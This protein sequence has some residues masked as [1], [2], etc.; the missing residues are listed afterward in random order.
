M[1]LKYDALEEM[2][3]NATAGPWV[4]DDN[5]GF[6]GWSIWERMTPTGNGTPGKKIAMIYDDGDGPEE[7]AQFIAA[8]RNEVPRLI[9]DVRAL[10]EALKE[11]IEDAEQREFEDWLSRTKPSGDA[12]RVQ[13]EWERSAEF[14]DVC[15]GWKSARA[16]LSR[17]QEPK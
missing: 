3:K 11:R 16:A 7:D 15:E 2:A 14:F 8:A 5:E 12:E 13:A 1:K 9:A 10:A 17:I 6:S 4:A